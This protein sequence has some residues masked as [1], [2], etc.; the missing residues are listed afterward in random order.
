MDPEWRLRARLC[1]HKLA[2]ENF[3]VPKVD[4]QVFPVHETAHL[5]KRVD[6]RLHQKD[7]PVV[8]RGPGQQLLRQDLQFPLQFVLYELGLPPEVGKWPADDKLVS[9]GPKQAFVRP[10]GFDENQP[11]ADGFDPVLPMVGTYVGAQRIEEI[12]FPTEQGV[13]GHR[14]VTGKIE[15]HRGVPSGLGDER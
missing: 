9:P 1:L 14:A 12:I 8:G 5:L 11:H 6:N 15:G 3:Q 2:H 13:G 4:A 10:V 7:L